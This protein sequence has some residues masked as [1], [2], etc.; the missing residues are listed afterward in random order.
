MNHNDHKAHNDE[1]LL[2]STLD[3]LYAEFNYPDSATDPIQIVR[4]FT[5]SDDRE[6]VGFCAAALAFGRVASVIQSIERLLAIVGDRP[7]AYVRAFDPARQRHAFAGLVHR[8]IGAPDV[9]ALLWILKQM[10]DR[11]GSIEGFFLEGDDP[12]APD[13][14]IALDSFSTRALQ[15]DLT[16]AYGPPQR[17]RRGPPEGGHHVRR[18]LGVCYFFPR[19]SA[20]SACKRLNLFLRWMVRRDELD[21]GVWTRLSPARL[22]VPLDTHVIRVGRCLRLT[23]YTSPGWPMAR[24]ITRTLSRL[25]LADPVKYDFSLCHLGMMNACGFSRAQADAHCPLRGVC[26][27]RARARRPSRRPSARR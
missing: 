10:I 22:V 12:S 9:V 4:R 7:A 14:S 5:R 25:D 13:I 16:A 6:V 20:G 19:P 21:L 26:R 23:R 8:W 24:D 27:P 2:K 3:R 11:A 18:A 17:Q 1:P 15:L